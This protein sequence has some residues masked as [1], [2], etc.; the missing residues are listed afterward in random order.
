MAHNHT[1]KHNG[2]KW[3]GTES[4]ADCIMYDTLVKSADAASTCPLKHHCERHAY[5]MT[6]WYGEQEPPYNVRGSH[7]DG[8][9]Y[10]TEVLHKGTKEECQTYLDSFRG[11]TEEEQ[12]DYNLPAHP[13][14]ELEQNGVCKVCDMY[15]RRKAASAEG[16]MLPFLV[17]AWQ[18]SR[19]Y[20]GPEEGGWWYDWTEV[21]DV[22]KAH[23]M[24]E[25][26][27]QARKLK[28]EYPQPRFNRFSCANR[29]EGDTMIGVFYGESDPR[30]PQNSTH[31]P[32]YE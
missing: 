9:R 17:V 2:V 18:I 14:L 28:A 4:C 20:G 31:R 15:D 30:F 29:G 11:L 6:A 21:V 7:N 25:G 3:E 12:N 16:R 26:L 22:R 10:Y 27:R 13:T 32:R 8:E 5:I 24:S 1:C 19:H 23:T